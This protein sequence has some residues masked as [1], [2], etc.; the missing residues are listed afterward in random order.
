MPTPT[1]PEPVDTGDVTDVPDDLLDSDLA[2]PVNDDADDDLADV[3][4]DGPVLDFG[5]PDD[6]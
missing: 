4:T 3:P 2:E 6:A 1:C 5:G